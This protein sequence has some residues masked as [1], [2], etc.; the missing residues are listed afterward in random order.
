MSHDHADF[1]DTQRLIEFPHCGAQV[2]YDD[3]V[4]VENEDM[5]GCPECGVSSTVELWFA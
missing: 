4:V 1:E 5:A 3:T 2:A